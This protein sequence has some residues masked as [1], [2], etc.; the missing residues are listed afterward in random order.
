MSLSLIKLETSAWNARVDT[1]QASATYFFQKLYLRSYMGEKVLTL[2]MA[3]SF[4]EVNDGDDFAV[5]PCDD[6]VE[7]LENANIVAIQHLKIRFTCVHC[8]H[9]LELSQGSIVYCCTLCNCFQLIDSYKVS[10]AANILFTSSETKQLLKVGTDTITTLLA[11]A[12]YSITDLQN[13]QSFA[14]ALLTK[15]PRLDV[16]YNS[17]YRDVKNTMMSGLDGQPAKT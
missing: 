9:P 4:T 6:S 8:A 5:Q 17:H 7:N 14:E 2:P 16:T 10:I 15:C 13:E 12:S 1:L 11:L 3:S